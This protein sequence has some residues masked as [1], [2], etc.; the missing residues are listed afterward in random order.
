MS[1]RT[2]DSLPHDFDTRVLDRQ[3]EG[4]IERVHSVVTDPLWTV[5]VHR[6]QLKIAIDTMAVFTMIHTKDNPV[7][8]PARRYW[9][10]QRWS[11]VVI[12][13][14]QPALYTH[15]ARMMELIASWGVATYFE[16]FGMAKQA[17]MLIENS[18]YQQKTMSSGSGT[19]QTQKG[20]VPYTF[21][22]VMTIVRLDNRAI[23]K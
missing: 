16:L 14:D 18:S 9:P 22:D 15:V 20:Q 13:S 10:M 4:I 7:I 1:P 17:A 12:Q 3:L 2:E 23:T 21:P 5:T 11:V 6:N 8:D 19:L